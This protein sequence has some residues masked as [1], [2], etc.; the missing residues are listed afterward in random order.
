MSD[1]DKPKVP[2][3]STSV[4]TVISTDEYMKTAKPPSLVSKWPAFISSF[5][6]GLWGIQNMYMNRPAL[7]GKI[8]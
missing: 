8:Y 6:A 4:G 5:S 7:A 1:C 3:F 2:W